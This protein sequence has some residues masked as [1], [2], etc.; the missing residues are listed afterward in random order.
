[1]SFSKILIA[2]RGEIACRIMRTA[3]AM[4]YRTVAVFSDADASAPHVAH[5]DEAICIGA[6]PASQSY[7]SIEAIMAAARSTGADAIHPGYGFLSENASFAQACS[8]ARLVFIGPPASAIDAMGNKA[9]AKQK[10]MAAGVPCAP[11]YSDADQGDER[12]QE[13]ALRLGF[14]LLVKAVAGGGGRGMRLVREAAG[15][16]QAIADARRESQSAFNDGTLMLERLIDGGRHIEIQ[17]F[18]DQHG[19]AVHLGERDCSSQRRRQKVIEESPSPV[20]TPAL[21]EAMGR[22]AIAAALAVGYQGAGTVEFIVDAQ[23]KH[24]FLEMNTRL[25]V[26]HPVTEM[27]TGL[28]L[29][30]WQLLV[31]AGKPLPLAQDQIRFA[32]HAIELRLCAEDPYDDFTPQTGRIVWWRPQHAQG[33]GTRIDHGVT[34]GGVVSPFYDPMLAKVIVHG[35]DRAE[36]IRLA[37]R[38]LEQSPLLGIACNDGFLHALLDHP[39]FVKGTM[40]TALIDQ[41]REAADPMLTRLPPS[42]MTWQLAAALV[43]LAQGFGWRASSVA[44]FDMPLTCGDTTRAMRVQQCGNGT[45]KVSD[46][47]NTELVR[48][49]EDVD[50]LVIFELKGV[51]RKCIKVI[52]GNAL[53]LA[54]Q[55]RSFAF[56]EVSPFPD[57]DQSVDASRMCATVAGSVTQIR[58]HV[59]D[60]V[61]E[62]QM[63]L[64]VEAMKMEMWLSARQAGT[65]RAVHTSVGQQVEA[66]AVLVEIELD[67]A[68]HAGID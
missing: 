39:A 60:V 33:I 14:P 34:E 54:F 63:L 21:R 49:L 18:A 50:G 67:I 68:A 36:A 37:R 20:V 32:G 61:R 65:V 15:M 27:V 62:N 38:S 66:G 17:V 57:A 1:M 51:R 3:H 48:V 64:C 22:D 46:M 28:D 29:V 24:Y 5:A 7:L 35:R 16:P 2:N 4:G 31:A 45:V 44:E 23:L 40:T 52:S 43:A 12:L 42:D 53:F 41:W 19:N 55:G 13:E 25:Q 56:T 11:G 47:L 26:E 30:A 9:R 10:M 59:G 8:D 6:A 58:I